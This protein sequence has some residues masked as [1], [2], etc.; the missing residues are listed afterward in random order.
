MK[1]AHFSD[2]HLTQ[3]PLRAGF[4]AK[5]LAALGSYYLL[6]RAARFRGAAERIAVL[7][8][9]IDAMQVTHALCTGDVTQVSGVREFEAVAKLF[10]TRLS[11]PD[12]FTCIPGNHD[13]YVAS[14]SGGFER[15]FAALCEGGHFPFEKQLAPG[16]RLIAIDA[17]RPT[18]L[19]DA[20]G[21]V[22]ALQR[23]QLE[24]M[25]RRPSLAT[26]FVIVALHYGLR[27]ASGL[28][29]T[30]DH[31]L[32]DDQELLALL[33]DPSLPVDLI[34]HGH[35]HRAFIARSARRWIL[36]AGSATDLGVDCGYYL[37]DVDPRSWE[38]QLSRRRWD[39]GTRRYVAD[40]AFTSRL[41]T[42]DVAARHP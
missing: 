19:F 5:R 26:Q 4:D 25:L 36:N 10:G 28:R 33:D 22:G 24:A 29:D 31:R 3:M 40:E 18:G 35:L 39:A 7:L 9:D 21:L 14:A 2:I 11:Q 20:S 41:R 6:G 17:A 27:T 12:R 16:V 32:L 1:L 15:H 23:N 37:V 38:A 8:S 30:R 34:L 13:R 42:R